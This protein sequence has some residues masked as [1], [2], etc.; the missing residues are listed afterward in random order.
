MIAQ[1]LPTVPQGDPEEGAA[2][3]IEVWS[4]PPENPL[5]VAKEGFACDDCASHLD[6]C[7]GEIANLLEWEEAV[8]ATNPTDGGNYRIVLPWIWADHA[9]VS[10]TRAGTCDYCGRS[11]DSMAFY[12]IEFFRLP[13]PI[14][15][16][17]N[18]NNGK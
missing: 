6:R 4:Y 11:W 8:A 12:P 9:E 3:P 7:A 5:P 10:Q 13:N 15:N 18:E 1:F 14:L 2:M 17:Q 16:R